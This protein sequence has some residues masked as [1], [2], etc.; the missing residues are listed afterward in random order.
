MR[1]YWMIYKFYPGNPFIRGSLQKQPYKSKNLLRDLSGFHLKHN[2]MS[3]CLLN[4]VGYS[5]FIGNTM[6]DHL[7][8]QNSQSPNLAFYIDHFRT[9]HNFRG[10]QIGIRVGII[11]I[12]CAGE[13]LRDFTHG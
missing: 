9:D 11:N 13:F 7:I 2:M 5:F 6:S 10:N 12:E 4:N 3:L 8:E 1:E